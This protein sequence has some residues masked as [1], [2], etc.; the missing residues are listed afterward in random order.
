M[1]EAPDSSGKL[2]AGRW[3]KAVAMT[4]FVT[5]FALG[6]NGSLLA[7]L[8]TRAAGHCHGGFVLL[9]QVLG[10][11]AGIHA[12]RL[13]DLE[14]NTGQACFAIGAPTSKRNRRGGIKSK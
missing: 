12:S 5:A 13:S 4:I 6:V 8:L 9:H 14:P 3:Q 11:A 2:V 7:E 10:L 1:P